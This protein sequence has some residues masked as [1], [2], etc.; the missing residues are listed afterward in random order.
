[1]EAGAALLRDGNK[2]KE[3]RVSRIVAVKVLTH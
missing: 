2:F 3:K 1:M